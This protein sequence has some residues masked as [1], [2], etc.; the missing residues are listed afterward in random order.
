MNNYISRN[1]ATDASTSYDQR[2]NKL[3]IDEI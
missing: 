2:R 3:T 1:R